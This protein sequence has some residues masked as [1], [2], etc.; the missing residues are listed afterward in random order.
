VN[1]SVYVETSIFSAL[2]AR[3]TNNLLAAARQ[4]VTRIWW[5]HDADSYSLFASNIVQ[6]E[7]RE[8]DPEMARQRLEYIASIRRLSC[9]GE[10]ERI[11]DS[12]LTAGI[13]PPKAWPDALHL[14]IA[15]V[16]RL[17]FLVSWNC[18]HLV[19][20]PIYQRISRLLAQSGYNAPYVCT[21]SLLPGAAR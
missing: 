7:A 2:V 5:Q 14:G 20:G 13:L 19:N 6:L 12:I 4:Q 10:C 3:P 1:P 16:H 21:P 18:R 8:G 9:T 17:E 15:T 11:A